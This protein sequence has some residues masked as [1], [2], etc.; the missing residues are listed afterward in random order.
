MS[1]SLSH[2][3][4]VATFLECA[5]WDHHVHGKADHRMYDRAAQRHLSHHPEIARD[6]L[7]TAVVCGDIEEVERIL[8]ER[9]AAANEPGGSRAW[10]PILYLCYA[11]FS[12][13][14]T[15]ENAVTIA[16]ALLDRDADP[17]AFY[18]AYNSRYTA[19]VGVAGEGEQHSP[20][21]PQ[22]KALFQLLLERGAEPFDI[23]V[24]YNTHF[25][26]DVLWWLELIYAHTIDSERKVVWDDPNWKMLDMGGYGTG[27]QFL[28]TLALI[29]N[30]LEL[31]E[32]CLSRGARPEKQP[33]PLE[34]KHARAKSTDLD[35]LYLD[36][37]RLDRAEMSAAGP[38]RAQPGEL[39]LDGEEGFVAA[40]LRLDTAKV[41]AQLA[42]HPKYL[43]SPDAMFMAAQLDRADVLRFLLDAGMSLEI[44]DSS[45]KRLCM[46][47]QFTT[48]C[49]WQ[50]PD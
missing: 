16:R 50:A 38:V 10:P 33:P 29:K 30:D 5:C 42:A 12:H 22:A 2:E 24:L 32:W 35:S 31:A 43:E 7:Y 6:S 17:N 45:G 39:V 47:Q 21:Q 37:L 3:S 25:S 18:Q 40:C 36:A 48:H 20:R 49:K 23:Q 15:I 19:L 14:P 1:T 11:R 28:L 9:P 46:K 34:P 44:S 41:K 8:T 26:G 4:L 27:A 13:Q